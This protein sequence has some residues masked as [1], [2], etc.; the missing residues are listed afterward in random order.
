MVTMAVLVA[1]AV[2]LAGAMICGYHSDGAED[3][4]IS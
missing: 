4:M 1:A 3:D 2:P